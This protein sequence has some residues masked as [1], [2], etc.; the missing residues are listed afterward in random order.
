MYHTVSLED[1]IELGKKLEHLKQVMDEAYLEL[2]KANDKYQQ[3]KI[4]VEEL[5]QYENKAKIAHE[6][7]RECSYKF[8]APEVK[9]F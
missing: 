3:G 4:F 9:E 5:E 1:F 2:E 6:N 7:W 8:A